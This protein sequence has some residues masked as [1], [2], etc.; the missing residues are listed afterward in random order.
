MSSVA[1]VS[2][3]AAAP[4]DAVTPAGPT[5]VASSAPATTGSSAPQAV[6]DRAR[7]ALREAGLAADAKVA[8]SEA[9]QWSDSSLGCGQPGMQYLQ[10]ITSGHIVR[11]V[12]RGNT[13]QVHVA[14]DQAVICPQS[15]TG[16]PKRPRAVRPSE[17][18]ANVE[19]ARA[20]LVALLGVP[21]DQVKLVGTEPK[22]WPN[23]ALGCGTATSSQEVNGYVFAFDVRGRTY[24]YHT[25]LQRLMACPPIEAQ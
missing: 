19:R 16:A 3:C 9:T 6:I 23:D 14:G 8:S 22:T 20:E 13:H 2:A 24:T 10:V 7:S 12:D 1:I 17:M 4:P 11:F 15:L 21:V 18:S 25:D 5:P